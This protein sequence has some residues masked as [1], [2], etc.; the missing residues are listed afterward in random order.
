MNGGVSEEF[1]MRQIGKLLA[2]TVSEYLK[3]EEHRREF[4][5]WYLEKYGAPYQ[6]KYAHKGAYE[7]LSKEG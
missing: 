5:K 1:T 2:R 4:E 3:D 6:F 7:E